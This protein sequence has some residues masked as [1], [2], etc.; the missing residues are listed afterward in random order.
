MLVPL[1]PDPVT[2]TSRTAVGAVESSMWHPNY[3][4]RGPTR[5]I[6]APPTGDRFLHRQRS[7]A[8]DRGQA[9]PSSITMSRCRRAGRTPASTW[10]QIQ[11]SVGG[12]AVEATPVAVASSG[13]SGVHGGPPAELPQPLGQVLGG[14]VGGHRHADVGAVVPGSS[15]VQSPHGSSTCSPRKPQ[16]NHRCSMCSTWLSSSIG[17][18][19]DGTRECAAPPPDRASTRR[20]VLPVEVEIADAGPRARCQPPVPRDS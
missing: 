14:H 20:R 13:A 19:P 12:S 2:T 7:A 17:V 16:T 1:R 8:R 5:T 9:S 4:V 10:K 6:A 11:R 3:R 18:Q 15:T